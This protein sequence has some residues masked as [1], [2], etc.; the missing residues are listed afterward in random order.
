MRFSGAFVVVVALFVTVLLVS[1]IIAVKLIHVGTLP[2]Q[3]LGSDLLF[4]PAAMVVFPV[5]YIIGDVLTEVYGFKLA[6][7]VI[8]LGFICNALGAL[9]IWLGGLIPAEIFWADQEAY[10][11]ILGQARW[12]L[13][14]SFA[15]YLVGEFSNSMVLARLKHATEGRYL[16][17]RTISSTVVGQGFDSFVFIFIAFG[18]GGDLPT[19]QLFRIVLIQWVAKIAYE[20]LA[21]PLTYAVVTYL[22]RKEQLDV[23]DP[24]GSLNPLSVFA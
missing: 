11:A 22:K 4:L 21:T 9:F 6:R 12:V 24:P 14:G 13:L 1:N 20:A 19:D 16:W 7:G 8:W 15:A 3:F 10:D 2:F 18:I 5:S 23:Y 17:L